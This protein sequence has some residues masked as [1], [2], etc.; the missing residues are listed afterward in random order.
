MQQDKIQSFLI[1]KRLV[2]GDT[3]RES[4]CSVFQLSNWKDDTLLDIFQ[5]GVDCL[6]IDRE[7]E[8]N[9]VGR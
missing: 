8:E 1:Y 4:L 3:T 9:E 2:Q 6:P 7:V 5:L